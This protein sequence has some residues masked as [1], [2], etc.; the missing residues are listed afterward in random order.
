MLFPHRPLVASNAS[1]SIAFV[2]ALLAILFFF[3]VLYRSWGAGRNLSS[4]G[5]RLGL[6]K[7]EP[8]TT[9]PKKLW[10]KLGPKGLS[11]EAR[12]WTDTCI[13]NNTDYR[14]EFMTEE[15]ADV[16]VQA[17]FGM[18]HPKLVEVYLGLSIP[19]LKADLLRY[20]LLFAEGGVYNDL[21]VTC[22]APIDDWIPAQYKDSTAVVVGWEFDVGWGDNFIR[23]FA[24][25]TIMAKPGSPHI[26]QVIEDTVEF[27]EKKVKENNVPLG[28]L[29][30]DMTGDV[31]D[32]TG[33]RRFTNGLFKS[34]EKI[35]GARASIEHVMELMEPKLLGDVLVLPGF[36]FAAGS[37]TY[38]EGVVLPPPLVTHHYAGTWKNKNGGEQ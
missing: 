37:N 17:A 14:V 2:S 38:D 12:A 7:P 21:D 4:F 25:W 9:I 22:D 6:G 3:V 34:M 16:Y 19:I 20:L 10:Y 11:D 18:R 13:R 1:R 32:A 8:P 33:P 23:E 26:W 28:K 35:Y 5:G 24:T 27:F 31:V 30:L 29:T 36:S 15:A